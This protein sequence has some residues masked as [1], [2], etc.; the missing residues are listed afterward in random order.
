MSCSS[1]LLRVSMCCA[2]SSSWPSAWTSPALGVIF[3]FLNLW[4]KVDNNMSSSTFYLSTTMWAATSARTEILWSLGVTWGDS[5]ITIAGWLIRPWRDNLLTHRDS[6]FYFLCWGQSVYERP[7]F[8]LHRLAFTFFL[9]RVWCLYLHFLTCTLARRLPCTPRSKL[10]RECFLGHS[11]F[12][13]Q[14]LDEDHD[15]RMM[16]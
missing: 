10:I 16:I 13:Q 3:L 8:C 4:T 2:S 1:K 15:K 12:F 9:C 7:I 6:D 11:L 5:S 14:V